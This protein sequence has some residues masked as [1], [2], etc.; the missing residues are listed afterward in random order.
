MMKAMLDELLAD[1]GIAY[2]RF[3]HPPVFTCDEATAAIPA[4]EAVQTKNL[5]LRD[6]RGRRHLLVITSCEKSVDVKRLADAADA[7]HLS[8][9]SAERMQKY[10]GVTP[11]SVT[12]FG[13][14]HDAEHA[15]E[16]YVDVDVWRADRWRCHPLVNSA[17]LV[18]S[19]TDVEKFLARTGH[20]ACVVTLEERAG[21]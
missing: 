3:D 10:L 19:R 15:V 18:L 13:L 11:G 12:V 21:A 17:T 5:F 16:L 1:L 20:M 6:K 2:E 4:T 14:M 7:D 9:A 8:F